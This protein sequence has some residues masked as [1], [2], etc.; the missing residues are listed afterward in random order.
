MASCSRSTSN[1]DQA[2][3]GHPG[4]GFQEKLTALLQEMLTGVRRHRETTLLAGFDSHWVV[5]AAMSGLPHYAP[6]AALAQL[7]DA[8]E[9]NATFD[10][11]VAYA[12]RDQPDDPCRDDDW[13]RHEPGKALP[14]TEGEP[15]GTL[16][17]QWLATWLGRFCELLSELHP[18]AIEVVM[19]RVEGCDNRGVAQRLGLPLR[20]VTR[21]V[22]D[23]QTSHGCVEKT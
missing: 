22:A 1:Q 14:A 9:V 18:R 10:W 13:P 5:T 23:I 2:R 4:D 8:N 20:L 21:V 6:Q 17:T 12:L 16:V 19:L 7:R 11:A 15:H 3:S